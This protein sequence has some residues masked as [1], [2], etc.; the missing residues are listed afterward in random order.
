MDQVNDNIKQQLLKTA[1][2]QTTNLSTA[3]NPH[4]LQFIM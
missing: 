2:G 1:W 4:Y 3:N